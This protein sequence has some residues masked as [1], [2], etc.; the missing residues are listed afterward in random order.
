MQVLRRAGAAIASCRPPAAVRRP[1]TALLALTLGLGVA[2][3]AISG[4]VGLLGVVLGVVAGVAPGLMSTSRQLR[5]VVGL[6]SVLAAVAGLAVAEL[7][8]GWTAA[9]VAASALIQAPLTTRASGSGTMLPVLA[10]VCASVGLPDRPLVL[11]LWVAAGYSALLVLV[12]LLGMPSS[13]TSVPAG[14][15]WRHAVALAVGGAITLLLLR[16]TGHGHWVVVTLAVVLRPEVGETRRN[17]RARSGGTVA[18]VVLAVV[19]AVVLPTW[20]LAVAAVP[21]TFLMI[22]WAM[23]RDVWRRMLSGTPLIV[24]ASNISGQSPGI[25]LGLVRVLYTVLGVAVAV[26]AV[27]VV[28]RLDRTD[29]Q[30]ATGGGL[31]ES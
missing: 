2:A 15:A 20:L 3:A 10:I 8:I 18:G 27:A 28:D 24:L 21:L 30:V 9:A 31:P 5:G 23:A 16:E 14:R 7:S 26:A 17:G 1:T 25:E 19:M 4:S 13:Q 6:L 12:R 22:A 11:A 29:D